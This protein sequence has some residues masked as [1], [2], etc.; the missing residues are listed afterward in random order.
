MG[1]ISSIKSFFGGGSSS[2]SPLSALGGVATSLVSDIYGNYANRKA[3]S[4]AYGY[5]KSLMD[6]QNEWNLEQWNRENEYNSPKKIMERYADAN[7]NPNLIYSQNP[8]ASAHYSSARPS[9]PNVQPSRIGAL[10][11]LAMQN[12]MLQNKNLEKQGKE[13]DARTGLINKQTT[14]WEKD[15]ANYQREIIDFL[16]GRLWPYIASKFK[17]G[18]SS[19]V[20]KNLKKKNPDLPALGSNVE[21]IPPDD[22][23]PSFWPW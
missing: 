11:L 12:A 19:N 22:W 21:G 23:S 15:H 7:L 18:P 17:S 16:R 5:Q 1:L 9:G 14:N 2:V 10:D 20:P 8:I 3:A 4:K 13:I 6:Y